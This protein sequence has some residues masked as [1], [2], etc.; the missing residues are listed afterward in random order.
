VGV[1]FC[2]SIAIL[3]RPMI[4]NMYI[5][6]FSGVPTGNGELAKSEFSWPAASEM[7]YQLCILYFMVLKLHLICKVCDMN[8]DKN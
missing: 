2:L 3:E 4:E 7:I 1:N 5:I 8:G 6:C